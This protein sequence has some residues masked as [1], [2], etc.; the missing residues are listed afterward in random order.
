M[1]T[2]IENTIDWEKV[3]TR[4]GDTQNSER[5]YISVI[6]DVIASLGGKTG[7]NAG[8]QQPVDIRDVVWPDGSIVSYECKKVNKG[9]RF[10]FNDTF[11]KPDVWYIF[12]YVELKRVRI[13]NGESL[14][15]ESLNTA[16]VPHKKH[17]KTIARIVIDMLGDDITSETVNN[18]FC[19]VLLFLKSCV[20]NGV[21]SY[22]EFGELFKQNINFGMFLSRPRPNWC[23]TVPYKP[24]EQLVEGQHSP[25]GQSS[26]YE[27]HQVDSP[28]ETPESL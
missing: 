21:L 19:E 10:M 28:A 16:T 7:S 12:I 24:H 1:E 2:L 26:P 4:K 27:N 6:L 14:I 5:Y 18:F 11:V 3:L 23:L 13:V 25:V 20:L 9:S 17:L 8:S 15:N 22:F